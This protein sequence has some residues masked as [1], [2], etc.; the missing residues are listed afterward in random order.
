MKTALAREILEGSVSAAALYCLGINS[1]NVS[2]LFYM[3]WNSISE[4]RN[5][6]EAEHDN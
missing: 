1:L 5:R 2:I 3:L 6:K 4:L